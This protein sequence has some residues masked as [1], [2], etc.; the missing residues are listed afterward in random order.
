MVDDVVDEIPEK[1]VDQIF[2]FINIIKTSSNVGKFRKWLKEYHKIDDNSQIFEGYK[3]FIDVCVRG[4]INSI[5]YGTSLDLEEDFTF[6]RARFVGV[7]LDDIP[8]TCEKTIFIKN[9]WNLTKTIRKANGWE[10]ITEAVKDADKLFFVFDVIFER[11]SSS[12]RELNK[13]DAL[14][15]STIFNTHIFLNDTNRGVPHVYLLTPILKSSASEEYLEKVYVGYV[16]TLQYL[17]FV[18]LEKENFEKSSLKDLHKAHDI[19]SK[20]AKEQIESQAGIPVSEEE[21]KKEFVTERKE[22]IREHEGEIE[23]VKELFDE[24]IKKSEAEKERLS[25]LKNWFALDMFFGKINEEIIEPLKS[26][27]GTISVFNPLLKSS[28]KFN[29][30]LISEFLRRDEL[31]N[32]RYLET[33]DNKER[34]RKKLDYLFLWYDVNVLNTQKLTVFNGVP[35]FI[36]TLIGN[37]EL[38]R[39]FGSDEKVLALRFKH[40]VEGVQGYDYSYG[41]LIQAFSNIGIADYS[42]WLIFFDCATDYSG[43]G[44]V[45]HDESEIFIEKFLDEEK[46]EIKEDI[47]DKERFKK[48][49][50]E[51]ST[52]SVFGEIKYMTPLGVYTELSISEIQRKVEEFTGTA[53]GKFFE[54][55]F[56]NWLA[57]KKHVR[58]KKIRCDCYLNKEQID[59]LAEAESDVYIFECKVNLHIGEIDEIKKQIE[60]KVIAVN[61]QFSKERIIPYLVVFSQIQN[62]HRKKFEDMG[63]HVCSPFENKIKNWRKKDSRDAIFRI[64]GSKSSL[65]MKT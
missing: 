27:V 60:N 30:S 47:V 19:Y 10:E 49:L 44:G 48:Y 52:S 25:K 43:A 53:K 4:F 8:N 50:A 40:P 12:T 16:Y 14:K 7:E 5:I 39:I 1:D 32:P 65:E 45:L 34:M 59:V 61:Q 37:V 9:V 42:G 63:I 2:S 22:K 35:A 57:E 11:A 24:D 20:E 21:I 6:F 17:W 64:L 26:R 33:T 13:N 55:L 54:Y 28:D 41:I 31:K 56:Y 58:Y 51:K 46:I 3:F 23:L 36:S 38:N 18:L 29:K 62:A 15:I